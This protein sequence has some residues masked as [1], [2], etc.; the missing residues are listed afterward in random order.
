MTT[1]EFARLRRRV[2]A[3]DESQRA[4]AD[5]VLDIKETVDGHTAALADVKETVGNHTATLDQH[6]ATLDQHTGL[7]TEILRR[8]PEPPSGPDRGRQHRS[9]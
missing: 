1:S 8:L 3:Y 2:E 6:T 5:T 9:G 7:L 4:L